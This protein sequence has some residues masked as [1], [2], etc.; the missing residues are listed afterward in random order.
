MIRRVF[1]GGILLAILLMPWPGGSPQPLVAAI[2][3]TIQ[4]LNV[5]TKNALR[6]FR[7]FQT[8]VNTPQS[9]EQVLPGRVQ[10]M[11]ALLRRHG[12]KQ[13]QISG[14]I[15]ADEWVYQQ[16]VASAWP[17]KLEKDAKA[18]FLLNPE[19]IG[20]GCVLVDKQGNLSFVYCP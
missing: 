17:R 13:F 5:S 10:A 4:E 1:S 7:A 16:I 8:D 14:S 18:R 15:A 3:S 9:G 6:R 19:P 11:L 2:T 12:V 20:L